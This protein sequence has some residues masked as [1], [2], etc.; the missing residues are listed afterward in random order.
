MKREERHQLKADRFIE[1][2]NRGIKLIRTQKTKIMLGFAGIL[3]IV[4]I[5]LGVRFIQAQGLKQESRQLAQIIQLNKD[6]SDHPEK[7]AEL[8]QMA[9]DGRFARLAYIYVASHHFEKEAYD[10]ALA[11]LE[12]FPSARK[13]I[14]YYQGM[15]LRGQ[16]LTAQKKFDEALG[17]YQAIELDAPKDFPLE[18]VL[19][20]MAEIYAD[21]EDS[22]RALELF[23]RVKDDFPQTFFAYEAQREAAKL[24]EKK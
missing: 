6:L 24:E 17:I 20:R 23:N 5:G 9:G 14:V 7:L 21:R 4:L 8:E 12:N 13:D 22:E 15:A 18:A 1:I 16:I 11:A 19:Y 3:V 2:V 10:Q